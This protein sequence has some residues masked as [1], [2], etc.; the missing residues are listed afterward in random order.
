MKVMRSLRTKMFM[1]GIRVKRAGAEADTLV[2]STALSG[3]E[4]EQK[5]VVLVGTY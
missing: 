1:T 4:S 2:V 5:P 3:A